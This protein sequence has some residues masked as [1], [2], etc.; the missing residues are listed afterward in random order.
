MNEQEIIQCLKDNKKNGIAFDFLPEDVR[1]WITD[2][3]S[4]GEA[5][6]FLRYNP[7]G[8]WSEIK[9]WQIPIDTVDIICL[10]DSYGVVEDQK[11]GWVEFDIDK[12]GYFKYEESKKNIVIGVFKWYNWQKFLDYAGNLGIP[13]TGFGGWMYENDGEWITTP[14]FQTRDDCG[15]PHYVSRFYTDAAGPA[16]PVK[17]R[18]W[19]E[20]EK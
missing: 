18:F 12:D 3:V 19:R 14:M 7:G 16:G 6:G 13:F 20:N 2:K 8:S 1:N 10:P 11:P 17:I 9:G 15:I 5:G 4:N